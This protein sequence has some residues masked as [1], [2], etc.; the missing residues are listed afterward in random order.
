VLR[1]V[2][3][4]CLVLILPIKLSVQLQVASAPAN[5]NGNETSYR[6][7]LIIK[8][9]KNGF[10]KIGSN[11]IQV[12]IASTEH[13]TQIMLHK[14]GYS[15]LSGIINLNQTPLQRWMCQTG[16]IL[17]LPGYIRSNWSVVQQLQRWTCGLLN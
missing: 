9:I 17:Y 8:K 6:L 4:F 10:R 15:N 12:T 7:T 11:E 14:I 16:L 3:L 1:A 2:S 13:P 5:N